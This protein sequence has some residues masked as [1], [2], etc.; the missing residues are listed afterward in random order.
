VIIPSVLCFAIPFA[1]ASRMK[2]FKGNVEIPK[3]KKKKIIVNY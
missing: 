2:I 1:L 3:R